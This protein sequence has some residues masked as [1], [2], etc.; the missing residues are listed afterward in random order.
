M[1]AIYFCRVVAY[2]VVL[3]GLVSGC[4]SIAVTNDAIEKILP[5]LWV[6]KGVLSKFQIV[7]MRV[8]DQPIWLLPTQAKNIIV[9]W[10]DRFQL[11][12]VWY[13]MQFVMKLVNQLSRPGRQHSLVMPC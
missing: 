2:V 10:A 5:L 4:A 9:M 13:P 6:L 7:K 8:L 3:T 1:K 12:G 11:S